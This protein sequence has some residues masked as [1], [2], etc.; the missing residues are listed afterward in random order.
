[1][2]SIYAIATIGARYSVQRET[3]SS[4]H[5]QTNTA[6]HTQRLATASRAESIHI[7]VAHAA[8]ASPTQG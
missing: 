7:Y 6:G 4:V 1:V 8:G 2:V 5:G 3:G